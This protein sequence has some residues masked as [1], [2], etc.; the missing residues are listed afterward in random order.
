[1]PLKSGKSRTILGDNIKELQKAGYGPEQ[2]VAIAMDK[3]GK[4][5]KGK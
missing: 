2:S 5:K 1:M 3:A 4:R